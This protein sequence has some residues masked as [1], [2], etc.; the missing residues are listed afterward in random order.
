MGVKN[1][2]EIRAV[3]SEKQEVEL[4]TLA[5]ALSFVSLID[6]YF[7]LTT[8][9]THYFCSEV[10]P[11]SLLQDIDSHCHGPI[12]YVIYLPSI[13]ALLKTFCVKLCD[14]HD[15]GFSTFDLLQ[16]RVCSS[17]AQKGWN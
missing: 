11:P 6:N 4:E 8:D 13:T 17:Q 3:L 12:M 15:G 7:R 16:V 9:S 10:A 2:S 5:V 1:K 14:K